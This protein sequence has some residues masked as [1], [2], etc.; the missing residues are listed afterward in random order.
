MNREII[1]QE[2]EAELERHVGGTFIEGDSAALGGTVVA[3]SCCEARRKRLGT[4]S[5]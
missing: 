3:V 5:Q 1:I 2:A 4:N